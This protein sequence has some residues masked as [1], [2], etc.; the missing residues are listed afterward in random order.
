VSKLGLVLAAVW[1]V[2]SVLAFLVLDPVL[3]AFIVIVV[4][5]LFVMAALARNWDAHSSF[6]DRE[7]ERARRRAE[8]KA[9]TSPRQEA[10]R[11]RDRQRWR[12]HQARKA[13]QEAARAQREG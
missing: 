6:E 11:E 2:G 13:A 3:A 8:R 10:A 5:V 4:G 7:M 12:E 9:R 1:V